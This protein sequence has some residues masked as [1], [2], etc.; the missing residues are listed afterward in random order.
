MINRSSRQLSTRPRST[1][2]QLFNSQL[3]QHKAAPHQVHKLDSGHQQLMTSMDRGAKSMREK[4]KI[5]RPRKGQ[6]SSLESQES[7]FA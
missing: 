6:S 5:M 3:R 1:H 2:R 4:K 7:L